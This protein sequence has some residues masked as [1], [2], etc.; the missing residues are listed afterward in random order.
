[1]VCV[2]AWDEKSYPEER[3]IIQH[4]FNVNYNNT[5]IF[6]FEFS[7]ILSEELEWFQRLD[8]CVLNLLSSSNMRLNDWLNQT[9]DY[10]VWST[11]KTNSL[12]CVTLVC[13]SCEISVLCFINQGP[14]CRLVLLFNF[15]RNPEGQK[16]FG[17]P[18]EIVSSILVLFW[19]VEKVWIWN[20]LLL[21]SEG[22][23]LKAH[24]LLSVIWG[25]LA[26]S[27]LL[28]EYV[29]TR[30]PRIKFIL[31]IFSFSDW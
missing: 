5:K 1:M 20:F 18:R 15:L 13:L 26:S 19:I 14:Q 24:T 17:V 30:N 22:F 9:T 7:V 6:N 3:D 11:Q 8:H 23:S 16:E 31:V 25:Q 10:T 21:I 2:K 12:T 29:P 28:V 4:L 27:N